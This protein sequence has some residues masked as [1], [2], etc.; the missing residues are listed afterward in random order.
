M[1]KPL[2]EGF[3]GLVEENP[4]QRERQRGPGFGSQKDKFEQNRL[5]LTDARGEKSKNSVQCDAD[6]FDLLWSDKDGGL[7][8]TAAAIPKHFT[9]IDNDI[10]AVERQMMA[11]AP[12]ANYELKDVFDDSYRDLLKDDKSLANPNSSIKPN[13]VDDDEFDF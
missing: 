5:N 11:D 6:R 2:E 3:T 7:D 12:K 9:P 4:V 8:P 1:S 13:K 10:A